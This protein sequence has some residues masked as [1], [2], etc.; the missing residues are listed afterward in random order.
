M[1]NPLYNSLYDDNISFD[2]L[3][4]DVY[5]LREKVSI[6]EESNLNLR[7]KFNEQHNLRIQLENALLTQTTDTTD[8]I[9][10]PKRIYN[11]KELSVE[12]KA[13]QE[14]Y[15]QHK[16]DAHILKT[17]KDK[18]NTLGYIIV[19][20]KDIPTQLVRMECEKLFKLLPEEDKKNYIKT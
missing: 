16:N 12:M 19:K 20:N 1:D 13:I 17:I 18:V 14:Y 15:K 2:E 9:N 5:C 8:D 11:R 6:L 3:L 4:Q 7:S 10:K